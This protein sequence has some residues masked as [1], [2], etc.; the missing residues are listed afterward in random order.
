VEAGCGYFEKY[1][2]M[3]NSS[4]LCISPAANIPQEPPSATRLPVPFPIDRAVGR[5][6]NRYIYAREER[7][8]GTL[9]W[10]IRRRLRKRRKYT[11]CY[12]ITSA[13]LLRLLRVHFLG[14]RRTLVQ[15]VSIHR[16]ALAVHARHLLNHILLALL[17]SQGSRAVGLTRSGPSRCR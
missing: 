3:P 6:T 7:K 16:E 15:E 10:G 4:L 17:C 14:L 5:P 8:E 2:P 1:Y 9:E 11:P 13:D 12:T